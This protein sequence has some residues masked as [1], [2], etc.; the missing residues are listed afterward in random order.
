MLTL[1][2]NTGEWATIVVAGVMAVAS[3][4]VAHESHR[5]TQKS[6]HEDGVF[7]E[8]LD[9]VDATCSH[10]A[11]VLGDIATGMAVLKTKVDEHERRISRLEQ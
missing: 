8:I 7:R 5:R 9:R 10:N 11:E 1:P 2:P 6:N 3:I 4:L